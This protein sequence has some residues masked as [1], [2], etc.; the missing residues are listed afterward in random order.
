[1]IEYVKVTVTPSGKPEPVYAC[2]LCGAVVFDT[3][4]HTRHHQTPRIG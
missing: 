1:M 2:P 3:D 4:L